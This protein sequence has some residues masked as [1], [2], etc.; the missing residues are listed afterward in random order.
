MA[1]ALS[2]SDDNVGAGGAKHSLKT[3][4]RA[5]WDGSDLRPA[6][7]AAFGKASSSSS[8]ADSAA[9]ETE[10]IAEWSPSR[11]K[12]VQLIWG[13]GFS[14]PGDEEHVLELAKPFGLTNQNTLLEIGS[15]LGGSTCV[16]VDKLMAYVD[17]LEFNADLVRH[18]DAMALIKGL[19]AKAKFRSVKPGELGLKPRYYDGC[20]LHDTLLAVEDKETLLEDVVRTLKPGKMIVIA[21]MFTSMAQ[22]GPVATASLAKELGDVFPCEAARIIEKLESLKVEIRV[23]TDETNNRSAMARAAWSGV[24]AR[25]AGQEIDEQTADVLLYETDFWAKRHEAF[26]VGELQMRRIVA[27]TGSAAR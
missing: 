25:L 27:L 6:D 1:L 18:A 8:S 22:P 19:E 11:Q 23:D 5:W 17:G 10:N 20:L 15:G 14:G 4:L 7:T 2:K 13:E 9:A 3:R 12:L 16:V 24:A 26:E 21:D